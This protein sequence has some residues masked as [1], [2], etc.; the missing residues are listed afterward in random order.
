[1]PFWEARGSELAILWGN[2]WEEAS[3]NVPFRCSFSLTVALTFCTYR[4][5]LRFLATYWIF[6]N[7]ISVFIHESI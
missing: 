5:W 2:M 6:R 4:N 3:A 7:F 1:L